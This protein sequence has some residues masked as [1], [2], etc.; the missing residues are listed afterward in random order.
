MINKKSKKLARERRKARVR[1]IVYGTAKR[2]RLSVFRSLNHLYIQLINDEKSITL[3]SV[4][5]REVKSGKK[6]PVEVAFETGK[7]IAKKALENKI[8]E[9]VFDR[10][11]YK[12][13]GRVKAIA[14]GAREEGLKF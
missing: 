4:S 11:G 13:H 6:K 10:S 8:K 5:D 1:S 12:Y 14:E 2:P 3:A 7:L 9:V